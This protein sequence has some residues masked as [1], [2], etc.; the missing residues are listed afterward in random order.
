MKHLNNFIDVLKSELKFMIH[1]SGVMLIMLGAIFIYSTLYSLAYHNQILNSLPIAV[2]D[3]SHSGASR[4]FIRAF[5]ASPNVDVLYSPSDMESAKKLFFERKVYG[6]MMIPENFEVNIASNKQAKVALYADASYFLMYKQTFIAF[7]STLMDSNVKLEVSRFMS[8]GMSKHEATAIAEPVA[9][10]TQVLF[11]HIGGY[12]TF[13]MPAIMLL[14]LQQT[15][16]LGIGIIGGTQ[17]EQKLYANFKDEQNKPFSTLEVLL[18]KLSAYFIF[19]VLICLAVFGTYYKILGYPVRSEDLQT[20]LFFVPYILSCSLLGI[21][22]S[23]TFR[24]RETAIIVLVAWSL[25]FLLISGVSFPKEGIP[26]FIYNLG[27]LL[28]SSSAING[29]NRIHVMGASLQDIAHEYNVMWFLTII[30][31][32]FSYI[33]L[34]I[35]LKREFTI[36]KK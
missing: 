10:N 25:P 2:I 21:A 7:T 6:V 36:D 12:A 5:D 15:L 26:S 27:Q 22:I 33:G 24:Y 17:R 20:L 19:S 1:D 9:V 30:Y 4:A 31:F 28:P 34:K 14:I 18:G 32:I 35:R 3:N 29:F 13:V 11:N 23:T 8:S 16:L